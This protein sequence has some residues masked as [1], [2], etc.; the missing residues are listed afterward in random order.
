[1]DDEPA[2]DT[3]DF[4]AGVAGSFA[5]GARVAGYRVEK[6]LGQGGMAVVYLARDERLD[7]MVALKV[8]APVLASDEEFRRR[9]IRESRAAAAVDD[10]HIIPVFEAGE[11]DGL[12]YIAMRYVPGRDVLTI[13]NDDGPL[14]PRRAAAIISQVASALDA[15]HTAGLV[16]RDVKPANMLVDVR[17]GRPDHVYLS[18][19]GLSKKTF[20]TSAGLT[21]KGQFLGTPDYTSPEQIQGEPPDGRADQ[22]GLACAAFELLTGAPPFR[23]EEA[24]A[25]MY[26]HLS[27]PPPSAASRRT[28][29]PA[30]VDQV[31]ARALAKAPADRYPSCQTFA[32]A[33][34]QA[35]GTGQ[36]QVSLQTTED[37]APGRPP[38][39]TA[40]VATQGTGQQRMPAADAAEDAV[41][42]LSGEA[43]IP[44]RDVD[45]PAPPPA[46]DADGSV[47]A[48]ARSTQRGSSQKS[49]EA[50]RNNQARA[51]RLITDAERIARSITSE[52]SKAK[53]LAEVAAALA[54][55]DPDRAERIARSIT[56]ESPKAKVLAEVAA[57]SAATDP[58]RAAR[59][60]ADADHIAR[61]IT[62]KSEKA[63]ALAEVA[64]ALAATDPDRAERIARSITSESPKAKVLAEVAAASAATDPDRAARLMADADHIARSITDKSEKATA[65]AEVAAALAAT[66]PDRAERIA[67]SIT[68]EYF[69]AKVLVEVAAALAAT[70]P[71]RAEHT[72]RSIVGEPYEVSALAI[73][74]KALAATDPPRAHLPGN[75][76]MRVWRVRAIVAAIIIVVFSI[77]VSWQLGLTV[78]IISVI[79]DVIYRSRKGYSGRGTARLTGAKRAARL[80][81]DAER[82]AQSITNKY[83]KASALA[84]VVA[85]LAVTDPDRAERIA[86]SITSESSKA[87]ALAEVAAALAVTDPDRA[88]R[89]ARSI[90]DEFWKA[91]A[92][93]MAAEA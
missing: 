79:A 52:S 39:Q 13:M 38:N 91:R 66:D 56:S 62:D 35:L 20:T 8:L 46:D 17:P 23:R 42:P 76:M 70:D 80:I 11:T 75:P 27:E 40:W 64:A 14:P 41:S 89:I 10:P 47:P 30:V 24:T 73:L 49:H 61:S 86:R 59:L 26:A 1:M 43:G 68:N 78:A 2:A 72:A 25:V 3:V 6:Q 71:D 48:R 36:H 69:K 4:L 51:A 85:A 87:N 90:T 15:A 5:A 29:L 88:E 18:D 53:V 67:R 65:L 37:P 32:E 54:A 58:D 34:L 84:E 44:T 12:L 57:A 31:L 74:A 50:G 19:F 21:G 83:W 28:D 22:Y 77:L 63:T 16:H 55:T 82:N 7:R 93:V 81:D 9:F 33:L 92:L 60:M 45:V